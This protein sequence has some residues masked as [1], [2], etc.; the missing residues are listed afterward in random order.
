MNVDADN[1]SLKE[2]RALWMKC[3]ASDDRNS[4]SQQLYGLIWNAVAFRVVHEA[5][6]LAA[7]DGTGRPVYNF[8]LHEL[9]NQGVWE[10]QLIAVRRLC[11]GFK[12][13]D[14]QRGVFSLV[15]LIND[16]RGEAKL[17]TRRNMFVAEG[18]EYDVDLLRKKEA[19]LW[20]QAIA[21][22]E[23]GFWLE[24]EFDPDS[25]A[26]RHVQIDELAGVNA[27]DRSPE[28]TIRPVFFEQLLA[29]VEDACATVSKY[30]NKFLAH[31]ATDTSRAAAGLM[32][33][34]IDFDVL[35]SAH[36]SLCKT[37]NF[38]AENILNRG[39]H[40]SFLPSPT[41][42]QFEFIDRPLVSPENVDRLK[43]CWKHYAEETGK[44]DTWNVNDL[45]EAQRDETV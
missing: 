4:I 36:E 20:K 29:K 38:V 31:A 16:I 33:F 12:L 11:D 13:T 24:P 44:W 39:R 22:G 14:T 2:K 21:K 27:A 41:H 32:N 1:E 10:S 45:L 26:R 5:R 28:D 34:S 40:T 42:N 9:L 18:L 35:W 3:F 37:A 6:Q 17:L 8:M 23:D 19:E 30:V 7:R 15:S 25:S 43:S